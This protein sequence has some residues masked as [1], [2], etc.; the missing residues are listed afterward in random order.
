MARGPRIVGGVSRDKLWNYGRLCAVWAWTLVACAPVVLVVG[1]LVEMGDPKDGL[2]GSWIPIALASFAS[3]LVAFFFLL[4][5]WMRPTAVPTGRLDDARQDKG[6]PRLLEAG[7]GAWRVWT[8]LVVTFFLL[9]SLAMMG[10]LVGILGS[11][12][13]AEGV[14]AGV[15]TAW[16]LV[17]LQDIRDLRRREGEEGRVYFAACRR[18]V[19]VGSTLVWRRA[20]ETSP[21]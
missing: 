10:A 17:W 16:G 18:P 8:A 21:A 15:L 1:A 19:S 5:M 7:R 6:K 14:V 12:G 9:G 11:G 13:M 20:A 2:E 4:R 3:S